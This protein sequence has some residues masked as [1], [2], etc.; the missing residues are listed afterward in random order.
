MALY[1]DSAHLDDVADICATFPVV[2]VTT[3]PSILLAAVERGQRLDDLAVAR[4]LLARCTGAVFMQ[5]TAETAE[6]LLAAARRY[7]DVDPTRI[8][9][10]LPMTA[11]GVQTGKTLKAEGARV[12]YT[13]TYTLA[14]TYIAAMAGADWVIPYHGRLRRAGI[15]A[16]ARIGGMV[17]LVERQRAP[18]HVLAASV[19]STSCLV[20]VVMAGAHDAT[21]PPEVIRAL[22]E[23]ALTAAAVTQFAADWQRVRAALG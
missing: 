5:P 8:V 23:D 13:A 22:S 14:Q 4:G 20:E 19:R 2:G 6:D 9:V 11:L 16:A 17:E 3:N 10:K 15:D 21:L 7:V 18:T 12:A 1:V